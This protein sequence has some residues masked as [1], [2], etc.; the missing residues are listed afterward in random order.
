MVSGLRK[1]DH[2]SGA[3]RDLHWLPASQ[4]NVY[5]V[6]SITR[7]C[8]HV[9]AP[10]YLKEYLIPVSVQSAEDRIFD[11]LIEV[12]WQYR[13]RELFEQVGAVS[14]LLVQQYGTA[15]HSH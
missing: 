7:R 15:Y 1:F 10:V 11:P 4:R 12:T 8:L 5:K 13:E 2:I 3:L 14:E 9:V 6:G